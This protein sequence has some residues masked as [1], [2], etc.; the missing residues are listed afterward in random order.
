MRTIRRA[1]IDEKGY[2]LAI[3]LLN[4]GEE[5]ARENAALLERR[6][7][8]AKSVASMQEWSALIES[9]EIESKG[10]LTIAKLYGEVCQSWASFDVQGMWPYEP[11]LLHE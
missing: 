5:V 7:G 6:L 2:F 8:Q 11:L 10:R 3:V 1:G 9:M 4:P